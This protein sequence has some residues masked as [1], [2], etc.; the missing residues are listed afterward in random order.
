MMRSIIRPFALVATVAIVAAACSDSTTSG[1]SAAASGAPASPSGTLRVFAF[2]DS[3]IPEVTEPF[4]EQYPDVTLET[5]A[6]GSGD[7][8]SSRRA[9]ASVNG[10][11]IGCM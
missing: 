10:F 6:F 1:S 8:A 2:E 5:A 7:E 9:S 3:I 4:N 11:S